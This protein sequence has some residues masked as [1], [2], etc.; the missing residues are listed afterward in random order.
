MDIWISV[1]ESMRKTLVIGIDGM[2]YHLCKKWGIDFGGVSEIKLVKTIEPS[3]S[4][5]CW[6]TIFSGKN[7]SEHG[8]EKFLKPNNEVRRP[9]EVP[10]TFIWN[11]LAKKGKICFVVNVPVSVPPYCF[12]CH[13]HS[14][15]FGLETKEEE[16]YE[17]HKDL[18]VFM[19]DMIK[20]NWD[21]LAVVY[22]GLDRLQHITKDM[23]K[24]KSYYKQCEESAKKL[25]PYGE[26]VIIVSDHGHINIEVG[27]EAGEKRKKEFNFEEH[28]GP[29]GIFVS[30]LNHNNNPKTIKEVLD[31]LNWKK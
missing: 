18:D 15:Y 26:D 22:L 21:F 29:D 13:F 5:R 2:D 1:G 12:N 3:W 14:K 25:I 8:I 17:T 20:K 4:P 10:E 6:A 19:E 30:N 28:H 31:C 23:E 16:I 11:T 24:I 9:E 27:H 7:A